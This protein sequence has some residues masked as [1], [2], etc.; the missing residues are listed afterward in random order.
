MTEY[1]DR[2]NS[3]RERLEAARTRAANWQRWG[4]YLSSGNGA[5]CAKITPPVKK[6]GA[7]YRT[8]MRAA[9]PIVGAKTV[10]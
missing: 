9:A 2:Q 7:I 10:C 8:T 1:A 3:E 5:L 6:L 4:S